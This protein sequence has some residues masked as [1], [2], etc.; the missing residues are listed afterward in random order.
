MPF[1]YVYR[2]V[3]AFLFL[4]KHKLLKRINVIIALW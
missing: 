3:F 1:D 2:L 4:E